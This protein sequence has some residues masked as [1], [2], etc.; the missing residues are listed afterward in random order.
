MTTTGRSSL[1]LL[2]DQSAEW[3]RVLETVLQRLHN[4]RN[5]ERYPFMTRADEVLQIVHGDFP[6]PSIPLIAP[7][8][9]SSVDPEV[10]AASPAAG[11]SPGRPSTIL[12][13]EEAPDP[14]EPLSQSSSTTNKENT[15]PEPSSVSRP[16]VPPFSTANNVSIIPRSRP[17]TE[18]R[19]SPLPSDLLSSYLS[20]TEALKKSFSR[21]PPYTVQRLAELILYPRRHYRFLPPY[22]AALDRVVSV[23]SPLSDFPLPQLNTGSTNGE[24]LTNGDTIP[25]GLNEREGLGSDESLGGALLTP[26]PWLRR[27]NTLANAAA[28][29]RQEGE[30]RS[31][32]SATIEGP[33]GAGRIETVSVMVNG[34]P[35]TSQTSPPGTSL[36]EDGEIITANMTTE[37]ALRAEGAVTQGELLRQ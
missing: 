25:N 26:I 13:S 28:A 6:L 5:R 34:V 24:H 15:A 19:A 11:P 31:E 7:I 10:I 23:Q 32:T 17:E 30:L 4:V 12:Q 8:V 18:D 35:S 1:T 37:Q 27:E 16:A 33:N 20:S 36:V 9:P 3:P 21:S 22:L 29:Q 2:T 14:L